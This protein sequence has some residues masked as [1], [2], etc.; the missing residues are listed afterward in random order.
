MI[1]KNS[2]GSRGYLYFIVKGKILGFMKDKQLRKQ[3]TKMFSSIKNEKIN[4][5]VLV[6]TINNAKQGSTNVASKT[7]P[8]PYERSKSSVWGEYGCKAETFKE[9][10]EEHHQEWILGLTLTQHEK[11]YQ[12]QTW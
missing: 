4:D 5:V 2:R 11:T 8:A 7:I 9:L 6:S 10:T 12:V 3:L 1:N